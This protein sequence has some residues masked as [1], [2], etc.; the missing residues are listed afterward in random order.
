MLAQEDEVLAQLVLGQGGRVALEVFSQLAN[1]AHILFFGRLAEIFKLDVLL[2]FSDRR[3]VYLH[4]PGRMPACAVDFPANLQRLCGLISCRGAAQFN[5][6][7]SG[8][9]A[10][11]LWFHVLRLSRAVPECESWLM[12]EV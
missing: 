7:T 12:R 6:R 8:N 5:K 11:P 9:G 2:E 3:I 4:R 10:V 1:I